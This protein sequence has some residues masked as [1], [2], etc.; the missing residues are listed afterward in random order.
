MGICVRAR[1]RLSVDLSRSRGG[2]VSWVRLSLARPC[3][4]THPIMTSARQTTTDVGV[5][6]HRCAP[7]HRSD[8]TA[9]CNVV[10]GVHTLHAW[11]A[12][13]RE[14]PATDARAGSHARVRWR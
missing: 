9:P 2:V 14:N 12:R 5:A 3:G 6:M 8:S 13:F 7:S 11:Y 4:S 1:A 10:H